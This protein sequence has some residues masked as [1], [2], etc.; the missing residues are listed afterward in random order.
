MS[1]R[2]PNMPD[3]TDPSDAYIRTLAG[4]EVKLSQI[5]E[6]QGAIKGELRKISP[7]LDTI[8]AEIHELARLVHHHARVTERLTNETSDL[9]QTRIS[10]DKTIAELRI[11]AGARALELERMIAALASAVEFTDDRLRRL[12]DDVA[13]ELGPAK[14]NPTGVTSKPRM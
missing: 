8:V 14:E 11:D 2:P 12:R 5:A 9:V 7:R 3:A 6:D 10:L 4:L 13:D 1:Q